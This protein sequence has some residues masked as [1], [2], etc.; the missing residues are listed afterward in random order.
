MVCCRCGNVLKC[1]RIEMLSTIPKPT[2][3]SDPSIETPD[4]NW[5]EL[6]STLTL[7][8]ELLEIM[9]STHIAEDALLGFGVGMSNW[10]GLIIREIDLST[11]TTTHY[12]LEMIDSNVDESVV[13]VV[14]IAMLFET[15][16]HLKVR[17][18]QNTVFFREFQAVEITNEQTTGKER[19][20]C[21]NLGENEGE[22][23]EE[24]TKERQNFVNFGENDG[25][26][27]EEEDWVDDPFLEI[28]NST[29]T[30]SC[31]GQFLDFMQENFQSVCVI[32]VLEREGISESE[33][34]SSI[35]PIIVAGRIKSRAHHIICL[36]GCLMTE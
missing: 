8:T 3:Y 31:A 20:N 24:E 21:V 10:R 32:E 28:G 25:T 33:L 2:R 12:E 5:D 13:Q 22:C 4:F 34:N 6:A 16:V 27:Y 14:H 35:F 36:C 29:V 17:S 9:C 18:L 26:G 19:Q 7:R 11:P 15:G 1:S 30:V 23:E